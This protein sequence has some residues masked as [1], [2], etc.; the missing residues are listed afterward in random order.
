MRNSANVT[1]RQV[2]KSHEAA[3]MSEGQPEPE[4]PSFTDQSP[5]P[6]ASNHSAVM[7][8]LLE[9]T[10]VVELE[11]RKTDALVHQADAALRIAEADN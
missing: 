2:R 4:V 8:R 9:E 7:A 6:S 10:A 3:G 11:Q 5:S 1:R